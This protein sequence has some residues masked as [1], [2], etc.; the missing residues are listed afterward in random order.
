LGR[1]YDP[2]KRSGDEVQADH[3]LGIIWNTQ[4]RLAV[5]KHQPK[6]ER[7]A[8]EERRI[9]LNGYRYEME[10]AKQRKA[11][12]LEEY[13]FDMSNKAWLAAYKSLVELHDEGLKEQRFNALLAWEEGRFAEIVGTVELKTRGEVQVLKVVRVL[14][15][16][17]LMQV[18]DVAG[19][20]VKQAA[21][22]AEQWQQKLR[23]GTELLVSSDLHPLKADDLVRAATA[24]LEWIRIK[25]NGT[26]IAEKLD[27]GQFNA[28]PE[29]KAEYMKLRRLLQNTI[30][31]V[32]NIEG[33]AKWVDQ[34]E[35][36]FHQTERLTKGK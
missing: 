20:P 5:L 30:S 14:P 6:Q 21:L 29:L 1:E 7:N 32:N 36:S 26:K 4:D 34:V 11:E 31:P 16:M 18:L 24:S 17:V 12:Y 8:I 35:D 15:N 27:A 3:I 28:Q 19:K 25:F 9:R 22:P 13:E 10:Q 23:Q 2:P 33:F